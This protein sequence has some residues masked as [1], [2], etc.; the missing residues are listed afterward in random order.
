MSRIFSLINLIVATLCCSI[1]CSKDATDTV[2]KKFDSQSTAI[3]SDLSNLN[4]YFFFEDKT[5]HIW[6]GTER[7]LNR[8]IGDEYVQYFRTDSPS[9]INNNT[10]SGA[11]SDK[12]D[13]L[14]FATNSGVCVYMGNDIFRR[15]P[16]G[17]AVGMGAISKLI[18]LDSGDKVMIPVDS[19][20]YVYDRERDAF[21][22]LEQRLGATL[23]PASGLVKWK[24]DTFISRS[25]GKVF[26]YI[27]LSLGLLSSMSTHTD[28]ISGMTSDDYG[29][30]WYWNSKDIFRTDIDINS[31]DYS[32]PENL[33][34][35]HKAGHGNI[36]SVYV[37]DNLMIIN[38]GD[39][40][41]FYNIT[42][43]TIVSQWD[44][45]SPYTLPDFRCTAFFKDSNNNL[46]TGSN[47]HGYEIVSSQ[48][49]M[50]NRN[51]LLGSTLTD[52]NITSITRDSR[53]NIWAVATENRLIH[54]GND[55]AVV[56]LDSG[57]FKD[58]DGNV[59]LGTITTDPFT[60]ETYLTSGNTLY[61]FHYD[62]RSGIRII[63]KYDGLN[64]KDIEF[65]DK[66]IFIGLA[67]GR[68]GRINR[69]DPDK[70]RHFYQTGS[71]NQII[72]LQLLHDGRLAFSQRFE[73]LCILEPESSEITKLR[74]REQL[75]E[76]FHIY[77][78]CEDDTGNLISITRDFGAIRYTPATEQYDRI[79]DLSCLS[80]SSME[81]SEDGSAWLS[82]EYGLNMVDLAGGKTLK[83]F[84]EDGIGGNQFNSR[85]SCTLSDGT[86][87]FGG[88]HGITTCHPST[89]QS[90]PTGLY[91][92]SIS[93]ND[94][95][96]DITDKIVLRY[97][98]NNL[99]V[100]FSNLNYSQPQSLS[101][102]YKLDGED[103]NWTFIGNDNTIRYTSLSRGHYTLMVRQQSRDGNSAV[104]SLPITIK[105]FPLFS[106]IAIMI[107]I[108]AVLITAILVYRST[109]KHFKLNAELENSKRESQYEKYI[110]RMNMNFFA[111]MAHEF[112][113]PLSLVSAPL[114]QLESDQSLSIDTH[115]IVS[116]MRISVDRLLKLVNELLDFNKL[117]NG[118][119]SLKVERDYPVVI[120]M[121]KILEMFS[122]NASK[123]GIS[124]NA[125]G[126]DSDF[127]MPLDPDKFESIITNLLSNAI[128]F[129]GKGKNNEDVRIDVHFSTSDGKMKLM[130]DNTGM[131]ISEEELPKVFDRYYQIREHSRISTNSGT[132]IGLNYA[133]MLS[134]CL[135]GT[136]TAEN[137]PEGEG[138]RFIL[139]LPT[140]EEAFR[141]ED[142]VTPG[143][144]NN[145]GLN[146]SIP[147]SAE[148]A[149]EE[150]EDSALQKSV[151]VV[152]D[153]VD[154]A[155]YL[156]MLLSPYYKVTCTYSASDAL[157]IVNSREMPDVILSDIIMP[158]TDGITLCREIKKNIATC[159]IPVILVTAK[160]GLDNEIKG[161][162]SGADAYVTKPFEP[163]YILALLKSMMRNR[164]LLKGEIADGTDILDIHEKL[165]AQDAEFLS[166]L[167]NIMEAE[168]ANPDLDIERLCNEMHISR[169]K[170]F[171]K[172]KSLTGLSPV[173]LFRRYRLNVAAKMLKEGKDSIAEV[174]YKVGFN[175]PSY[176]TRAFKAQFGF[177]PKESA[178]Q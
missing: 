8:N 44:R 47:G 58:S 148:T 104:I 35:W 165:S 18:E 40:V 114:S 147:T 76:M 164:D 61:I 12:Q 131:P 21:V 25:S 65:S 1:S 120:R 70:I 50:F 128:K 24:D 171:N 53:D 163:S 143:S 135:H 36:R 174:A 68:I 41:W 121:A 71:A 133:K 72:D 13:S 110:N 29:N 152:D 5:G 170:L 103:K 144:N 81:L 137:R 80:L 45:E 98:E 109:R 123:K 46:W 57:S 79:D 159:H 129:A 23:P 130:V 141:E 108:I 118:T 155:N 178:K 146:K 2:Q 31:Q 176:F 106:R 30:L 136:L 82:S 169:T 167:Y 111:N 149:M 90:L 124:L 127:R 139:T 67:N 126:F 117:D 73:D 3:S 7:G 119:I 51:A 154:I 56:K 59:S 96:L 55:G 87:I 63:R 150:E 52:I 134:E 15:I 60:D 122:I 99:T 64:V 95:H 172:V 107:Y 16:S 116:V 89:A 19:K 173:P 27:S 175:T 49:K 48:E 125:Y 156:S 101:N 142:F 33:S 6:I 66:S 84:R 75:G 177:L 138:V 74:Y 115:K 10:V 38:V 34:K 157:K 54:I 166:K 162:E 97:D 161:F 11:L 86:V 151:L 132:G 43:D 88:T 77:K 100:R 37:Y 42:D 20:I 105:P 69:T 32:L 14:W 22:S 153:E 158:D 168:I 112:R 113:T 9:S 28:A 93:V 4:V 26:N 17:A 94:R 145:D 39:C 91:F 78:I 62:S 92:E 85:C 140:S 160:V 102:W 83:F